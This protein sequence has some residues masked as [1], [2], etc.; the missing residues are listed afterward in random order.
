MSE[1]TYDKHKVNQAIKNMV[2]AKSLLYHTLRKDEKKSME[3][4]KMFEQRKY[5]LQLTGSQKKKTKKVSPT[6]RKRARASAGGEIVSI[7]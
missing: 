5:T 4:P 7:R 3:N 2:R 6:F 1:F